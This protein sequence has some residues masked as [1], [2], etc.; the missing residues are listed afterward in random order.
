LPT[1][2]F[3]SKIAPGYG[4]LNNGASD[5]SIDASHDRSLTLRLA[6]ALGGR[7][8]HWSFAMTQVTTP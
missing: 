4:S 6:A 3:S 2:S 5:V 8:I 1:K 7:V